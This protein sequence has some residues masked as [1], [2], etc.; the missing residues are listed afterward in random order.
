MDLEKK[1][2]NM[3][4]IYVYSGKGG[5]GKSSVCTNLAYSFMKNG[6][7]TGIFDA[8]LSGPS[9]P[10][11]V[12]KVSGQ[13]PSYQ[14]VVIKPGEYGGVKITSMGLLDSFV[15]HTYLSGK[16]LLGAIYQLV[17]GVDWDVDYLLIDLPP[18]TSDIHKHLFAQLPGDVL[19]VTTPQEVSYMDTRRSI[20]FMNRLNMNILGVVENMAYY[21]CTQC[22]S[23][24]QIFVGDTNEVLCRPY[25]LDLL[26]RFPISREFSK[27]S[28]EGMPFVL[29][30]SED[31][32]SEKYSQ[33]VHRILQ[34]YES[35]LLEGGIR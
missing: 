23:E 26:A 1:A 10:S 3:K 35:D 18:G 13:A 25:S 11:L 20:E 4:V 31:E 28:N 12:R 19:V 21:R 34:Q 32:I 14:G 5:V 8:D 2:S 17:V 7:R 15:D 29:Q 22:G 24:E 33:L 30:H 27:V 6:Y 9:I 16:Y